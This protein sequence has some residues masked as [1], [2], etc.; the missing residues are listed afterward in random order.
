MSQAQKQAVIWI[1]RAVSERVDDL[2]DRWLK[3]DDT[4]EREALHAKVTAT[5]ELE[6]YLSARISQYTAE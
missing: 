4:T 1:R 2:T 6:D 5:I 3:S